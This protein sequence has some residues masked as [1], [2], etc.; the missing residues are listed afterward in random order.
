MS[1]PRS[2]NSLLSS[3]NR[4]SYSNSTKDEL[5]AMKYQMDKP[6]LPLYPLSDLN[7]NS[8]SDTDSSKR[9]H[10]EH[11]TTYPD[12]KPWKDHTQLAGDKQEQ[13]IQKMSNTSFLNKGYFEAPQVSNEYYSAR[14]LIQATVFSST[15]N[16]NYVLRELSQHLANAYKTR[17]EVINKIKYDSNNFRIPPRVTLTATKKEAWLKDLGNSNI[18]I[19]KIGEKIPHGIR[20]KVLIDSVCSR[21]VPLNRAL[22]FTK[23]VL[24]SELL[25]LRRKHQARLSVSGPIPGS[26]FNTVEK[27]EIHWLQ[28]WT[29]QVC[30]YILKFSREMVHITT[31]EKKEH[32]MNKL[33]YLLTYVQ[34]LYVECLVDKTF[35]LSVIFKS[36]KDGLPLEVKHINELVFT[37]NDDEKLTETW[38]DEIDLNYGQRL[39]SLTLIKIFWKDILKTDY[40]CKEL[41]ELLLLNHLFINRISSLES[42]SYHHKFALPETL[43]QNVLEMISNTV[44]YLFKYNT[45]VFIIPKYW[46][47]LQDPLVKIMVEHGESQLENEQDEIKNQLELIK[48]RNESLILN[49][50]HVAEHKQPK[51]RARSN[52]FSNMTP[53]ENDINTFMNRDTNDILRILC[54]LDRVKLNND[55]ASLLKPTTHGIRKTG[56]PNWRINL[57]L[58]LFWCITPYRSHKNSSEGILIVC[59]FLKKHILQSLHGSIRTEFETELLEIIYQI[60]ESYESLFVKY[61]LYVLINELY[62][63]KVL[64]IASYLRKLIA[65]GIFFL[66]PGTT[67]DLSNLPPV[68]KIHLDI[69]QS[70]PVLNNRQ[71]D[72][73]LKKW[74]P[75]GFNFKDKFDRGQQILQTEIIDRLVNN[76]FNVNIESNWNYIKSLNVGL[77]F[78][79]VNWITNVLKTT[80]NDSPKLIHFDPVVIA[81]LYMF[82]SNCDNLT[83]FF[84][85][86]VKTIL[87]NEGGMIIFYLDSLYFIAKLVIHHF[88]LIKSLAGSNDLSSTGYELFK[89][90]VTT[91][92]DLS[93]REYNYF[94]FN[95]VW[96]FIDDVIEKEYHEKAKRSKVL[97]NQLF[98]K[99]TMDTPMNINT[100][101]VHSKSSSSSDRYTSAD[102]RND[103]ETLRN[104]R[105]QALDPSEVQDT[106]DTLNLEISEL[107]L[108]EAVTAQLE[109][110]FKQGISQDQE[111]LIIKLLFNA[112]I[113]LKEDGSFNELVRQF[114][115]NV[116]QSEADFNI[117]ANFLKKL[118]ISEIFK[119]NDLVSFCQ[120]ESQAGPLVMDVIIGNEGEAA[121]LAPN[122]S[123]GLS[124]H[125]VTFREKS[126]ANFI[127]ILSKELLK[128]SIFHSDLMAK[129]KESMLKYIHDALI[130][131]PKLLFEE[132]FVKL[133]KEDCIDLLNLLLGR[134]HTTFIRQLSDFEI[135]TPDINE[136][137]LPIVQMLIKIISYYE[138]NNSDDI[139][140][141]LELLLG[142]LISKCEFKFSAS[143]SFFGELFSFISWEH[144]IFIL[145]I[146]ETEFLTN[147]KFEETISLD[148]GRDLLPPFSD[149]FN[150]FSLSSANTVDCSPVFFTNLCEFLTKLTKA[151]NTPH[152]FTDSLST[153]I[154]IF[155]RILIIHN[156]A[157]CKLI[158]IGQETHVLFIQNLL[159]ILHSQFLG[160]HE[161]LRILLYDLLLLMK[162]SVTQELTNA[163]EPDHEGTSPGFSSSAPSDDSKKNG[164]VPIVPSMSIQRVFELPD[165]P[166]DDN[167]FKDNIDESLVQCALMLDD[168]ELNH[169]GDVHAFNDSGL[170]LLQARPHSV[171]LPF[172]ILNNNEKVSN[173]IKMVKFRSFEILEDTS[174]AL[175]DGCVNLQL[176]DAYTTRE[177]PP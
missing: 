90:I 165:E 104:S 54:C 10:E 52:S 147:T 157:L 107:S 79:L 130:I 80:L 153:S 86:L 121:N 24:F 138:L 128:G 109:Y 69:L 177:N 62:Q 87:R 29:Q 97:E 169:G 28:E 137:N 151:V 84:K 93:Q 101:D 55:L 112:R 47:L 108:S 171:S 36:L 125:R 122:E 51:V 100:V 8:S 175:N 48:Y 120:T 33:T 119:M 32:Y 131:H 161:K 77:K 94:S 95:Q 99:D 158:S 74:T 155:L 135:L 76:T 83:V 132:L 172:G 25:A 152:L 167:P 19:M 39:V 133:S 59:N 68:V 91:Y 114:V 53:I 150:K 103:L 66:A 116:M 70:L 75:E 42:H 173:E 164:S 105:V 1:K 20:N 81:N 58:V 166:K 82:Y 40:L 113:S 34:S 50:K 71:C 124:I 7:T 61:N 160:S 162:S 126:M 154:L 88:K 117:K 170:V 9:D 5:L 12:F 4:T 127:S 41:S 35:F 139:R 149:F 31:P 2:R 30:D 17:N 11:E 142:T 96:N 106:L 43:A 22:W 159:A 111:N 168:E 118:V 64:T 92:K 98:S 21:N 49:L 102:F 85:V 140:Q 23:C 57:R 18:P 45:N 163:M 136:F 134:E 115:M 72:S 38:I 44:I 78:L 174:S 3:H 37:S 89:L 27:F 6:A 145:D 46:I 63:L 143:N 129:H 146:I 56:C 110:L 148:N 156:S 65:S 67:E 123:L 16:C 144:K 14:N 15:D 13:E 26:E 60:A 73:I 141:K 176:L